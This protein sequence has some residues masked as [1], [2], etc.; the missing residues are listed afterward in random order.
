MEKGNLR[1]PKIYWIRIYY[2][3]YS[4]IEA[5]CLK[6]G[7]TSQR[8]H[9]R[10]IAFIAALRK[11]TGFRITKYDILSILYTKSYSRTEYASHKIAEHQYFYCLPDVQ[12]HFNGYTEA[13]VNILHFPDFNYTKGE[14]VRYYTPRSNKKTH[15]LLHDN[16]V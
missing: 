11:A 4:E 3:N 7:F 8:I 10:A 6:L 14:L 9:N 2:Y 13:N 5:T 1:I 16:V 12:L 15:K